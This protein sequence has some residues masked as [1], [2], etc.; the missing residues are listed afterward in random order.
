MRIQS[1]MAVAGM[2]MVMAGST[3]AGAQTGAVHVGPRVAYNFDFEEVAIG[4]HMGLPIGNRID[5]YP[6]IDIF[7]PDQGSLLGL[8]ADIKLRP[9]PADAAMFYVGTGLN[10]TRV[11]V[12]SESNTEAGL[13]LLAGLEGRT[14]A[15]HPF[16][17][18]RAI[19]A[20][21]TSVQLVGGLNITLRGR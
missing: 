3:V 8:N 13:N 6:S 15:I 2:T 18:L 14:G 16:V 20:D 9:L 12:R 19:L 5:F 1:A 10:L 17:E 21:R 4:F 11:S 7:L